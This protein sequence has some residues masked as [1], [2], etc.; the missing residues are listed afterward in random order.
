MLTSTL[1]LDYRR[2]IWRKGAEKEK[3][4]EVGG[5]ETDGKHLGSGV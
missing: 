1:A 2:S 4:I 3:K 5:R